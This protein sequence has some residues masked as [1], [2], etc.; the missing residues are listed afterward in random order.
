MLD[1]PQPC[2]LASYNSSTLHSMNLIMKSGYSRS[3]QLKILKSRP[4]LE[5]TALSYV[6]GDPK[7]TTLVFVNGYKTHV[8]TNLR[9]ALLQLRENGIKSLWADALCI[10]QKNKQE[11]GHQVQKMG[12][13]YKSA[14][15]V[16]SWLGPG[17]QDT[18]CAFQKIREFARVQRTFYARYKERKISLNVLHREFYDHYIENDFLCSAEEWES[19]RR[20]SNRPYWSRIWVIQEVVLGRRVDIL[21]GREILKLDE[22]NTF[23]DFI[24]A[25]RTAFR[26]RPNL[27]GQNIPEIIRNDFITGAYP[28]AAASRFIFLCKKSQDG[29]GLTEI[30]D[31]YTKSR[32]ILQSSD[33]KDR[34]YGIIGLLKNSY[35]SSIT[36][37]YTISTRSLFTHVMRIM[38][39]NNGPDVLSWRGLASS[40]SNDYPSWTLDWKSKKKRKH[41]IRIHA[42]KVENFSFKSVGESIIELEAVMVD[43]VVKEFYTEEL[44]E[45][46]ETLENEIIQRIGNSP[47]RLFPSL[48][49]RKAVWRTLLG[50]RDPDT[51]KIPADEK[52]GQRFEDLILKKKRQI[53]SENL[54]RTYYTVDGSRDSDSSSDGKDLALDSSGF[55]EEIWR[56]MLFVTSQGYVGFAQDSVELGDVVYAFRHGRIP[57]VL[58]PTEDMFQLVSG[59]YMYGFKESKFVDDNQSFGKVRLC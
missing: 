17:A 28:Y 34:I 10:D 56:G 58:R 11:R 43:R 44:R 22:F 25:L 54:V 23:Q 18:A 36:V 30:A 4:V 38:L 57:F 37:D 15:Q 16:I 45:A 55:V 39:V 49:V 42:L 33:E 48:D 31:V 13:I 41:R 6:W 51:F 21:C 8:T 9:D 26:R 59:S 53:I 50:D 1:R 19:V 14:S 3:C 5:Y 29:I 52:W 12:T 32:R 24:L 20:V 46:L 7:I 40:N 47:Y 2:S 35:Q 27:G